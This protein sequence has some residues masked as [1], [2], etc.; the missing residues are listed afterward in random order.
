MKDLLKKLKDLR[1]RLTKGE[2]KIK[3]VHIKG[4]GTVILNEDG[5]HADLSRWK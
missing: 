4:M 5:T 1:N 2:R 3:R